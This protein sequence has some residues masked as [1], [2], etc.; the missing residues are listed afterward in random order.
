MNKYAERVLLPIM[1][2]DYGQQSRGPSCEQQWFLPAFEALAETV[3]V[4]WIDEW[5]G[6]AEA[7][8]HQVSEKAALI[9]PD[10]IFCVPFQTEWNTDTVSKLSSQY[11]TMAWF[12]DDQWRFDTFSSKLA[13]AFTHII[14]TDPFALNRYQSIGISAVLSDWAGILKANLDSSAE[15]Y[16]Y[17]V[18]FVGGAT[19]AR[20]WA[21]KKLQRAGITVECF[22]AGWP[23]GRVS[24]ERMDEIFQTSRINLNLSNSI[25]DDLSFLLSSPKAFASWLLATKRTEQV[26]AR[27]FEIPL[28]GGFQL[29]NYVFGLERHFDIGKE[30]AIFGSIDECAQMI[31]FYLD[32][33]TL[34]KELEVA[35]CRRAQLEHTY[36]NRLAD[37]MR[38]VWL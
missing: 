22:G 14:T 24:F 7:L 3:E 5:I 30:I 10:L 33:E 27:N 31:Q 18:S 34:R 2:W 23:N 25:P 35:G 21:V 4:L 6:D 12:G 29:T 19:P 36:T 1:R 17:D 20:R 13:P 28:V 16:N 26:K 32:H 38:Q 37:V 11:P 8:F 15:T 9:K